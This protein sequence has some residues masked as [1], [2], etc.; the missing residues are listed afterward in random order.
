ML[1][2]IE[3]AQNT[4]L[5]PIAEIAEGLGIRES[6]YDFYGRYKAKLNE[7]LFRRMENNRMVS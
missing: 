3:I 7:S 6:E 5:F 2:D 1:S 4:E